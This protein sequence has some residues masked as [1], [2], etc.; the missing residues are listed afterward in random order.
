MRTR[1]RRAIGSIALAVALAI[2]V[3]G[4][5]PVAA[6][7]NEGVLG[8]GALSADVMNGAFV[9]KDG[10]IT[11]KATYAC[12]PYEAPFDGAD[13]LIASITGSVGG[14]DGFAFITCDGTDQRIT[15]SLAA[16][17][18][19]VSGPANLQFGHQGLSADLTTGTIS[20]FVDVSTK[21][22]SAGH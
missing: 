19:G 18:G 6:K 21:V 14:Y 11:L 22:V 5:A 16:F 12:S 2:A 7:H 10:T 1:P 20:V 17:D 3:V 9:D 15:M 13:L 8:F 4:A